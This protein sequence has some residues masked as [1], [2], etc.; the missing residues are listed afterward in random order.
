MIGRVT[1]ARSAIERLVVLRRI[2]QYVTC[3][4]PTRLYAEMVGRIG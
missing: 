1:E 4:V 3:H 2:E